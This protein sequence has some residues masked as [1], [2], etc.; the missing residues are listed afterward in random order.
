MDAGTKQLT[1]A[2]ALERHDL[3]GIVAPLAERMADAARVHYAVFWALLGCVVTVAHVSITARYE[4]STL[5]ILWPAVLFGQFSSATI[6]ANIY[7]S[8]LLERFAPHLCT[9]LAWERDK[10]LAWYSS[11]LR[12]IFSDR[13]MAL[14]GGL[15]ALVF[16]PIIFFGPMFPK[17]PLAQVSFV[18]VMVAVTVTA[19]G[20]LHSLLGMLL[21]LDKLSRIDAVR[22]SV[23]QQPLEGIRALESLTTRISFVTLLLYSVGMSHG[24]LFMRNGITLVTTFI[25]GMVIFMVFIVPQMKIRAIMARVRR[26]RLRLVSARL[27]AAL[28]D[29][30]GSPSGGDDAQV[31]ELSAIRDSLAKRSEWPFD[32][33]MLLAILAGIAVP[34]TFVLVQALCRP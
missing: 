11:E 4:G 20:L 28:Q 27:E 1:H 25:F 7:C 16:M 21:M 2:P 10:T 13:Y 34:V 26:E 33:R 17:H 12:S 18:A 22:V 8:K 23:H 3:D 9:I 19:G 30:A 31:R 32:T 24:I 5:R 15:M 6:I 29:I 14:C